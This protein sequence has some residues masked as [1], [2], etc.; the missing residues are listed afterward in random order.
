MN[1]FILTTVSPQSVYYVLNT[2][3]AVATWLS[4]FPSCAIVLSRLT[5][6]E[7]AAVIQTHLDDALF[8]LIQATPANCQGWLPAQFWA[9]I[10]DP[11]KAYTDKVFAEILKSLPAPTSPPPRTDPSFPLLKGLFRTYGRDEPPTMPPSLKG[12]LGKKDDDK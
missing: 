3:R 11:E 6:H 7:L 12:L 8:L 5:L 1:A 9:Y 4:P 10:N 2:S